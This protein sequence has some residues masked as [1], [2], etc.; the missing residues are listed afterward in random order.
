MGSICFQLAQGRTFTELSPSWFTYFGLKSLLLVLFITNV[1]AVFVMKLINGTTV[2][3]LLTDFVSY[4]K[5]SF[6]YSSYLIAT[7]CWTGFDKIFRLGKILLFIL[8]FIQVP[9]YH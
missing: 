3:L 6:I 9:N 4:N 2:T 7:N 8:L 5:D 1:S